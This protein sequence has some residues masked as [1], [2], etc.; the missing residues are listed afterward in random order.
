MD[1]GRIGALEHRSPGDDCEFDT[2]SPV[3]SNDDTIDPE[4]TRSGEGREG[5]T[6]EEFMKR[7]TVQSDIMTGKP[8]I[9]G[10]RITVE[11]LL[12]ALAAGVTPAELIEEY[13]ELEPD[14]IKAAL[15]YAA[16]LVGEERVFPIGA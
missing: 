12:K 6:S 1:L 3:D 7:V 4:A 11:Q 14:D 15:G 2:P 5:M 10:L 8:V 13:P 9:R 16:W